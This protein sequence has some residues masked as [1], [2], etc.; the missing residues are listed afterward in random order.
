[1]PTV[2]VPSRPYEDEKRLP[3]KIVAQYRR[4]I[5]RLPSYQ[6]GYMRFDESEDV[7]LGRTALLT[8]A[9]LSRKYILIGETDDPRTLCLEDFEKTE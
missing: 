2:I 8:A 5:D 9:S 7:A 6:C 3:P 4:F 1:M